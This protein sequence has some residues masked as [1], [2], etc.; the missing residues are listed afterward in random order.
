MTRT[1]PASRKPVNQRARTTRWLPGVAAL[2]RLMLL[3]G[4]LAVAGPAQTTDSTNELWPEFDIFIKLN[5][6]SRIFVL[7]SAT[8]QEDL[9]AYA[10]GQAGVH[11]DFWALPVFRKRLI[12]YMDQSRSSLLFFR[13]GYVYSHPKN[14]STSVTE[15]MA[16][17]EITGRAH[18]PNGWLLGDRNRLDLRWIDG[19][20]NHRYRNRLKLER[21]FDVSRFQLTPYTHAE[22]FYDFE[23]RGWTRLRYAAGTEWAITKRIVLE[24]YYLRQNTWA[25]VP[26]F[27]NAVGL[28]VQVYF[29]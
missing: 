25:A 13:F 28:A 5:E 16:T 17:A 10:D 7:Y 14:N 3:A 6:K 26:Q 22:V 12:Q 21:T 23:K 19:E 8:K 9:G 29:R 4:F 20:P 18:L 1:A 27:V 11:L 15:S 24:G 2:L